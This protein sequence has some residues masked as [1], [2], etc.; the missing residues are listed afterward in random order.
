MSFATP[1]INYA[2]RNSKTLQPLP[3]ILTPALIHSIANTCLP[4]TLQFSTWSRL[5]SLARD[6]SD[7]KSFL[8]GA[9]KAARGGRS[10]TLLVVQ[11]MDGAIFGGLGT[12]I[13]YVRARGARRGE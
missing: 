13:W 1:S 12:D 5:F 2:H 9:A 11:T 10:E 4:R 6:G 3:P 8:A 7:F